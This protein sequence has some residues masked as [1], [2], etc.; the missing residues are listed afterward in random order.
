[1]KTVK[2]KLNSVI[3]VAV[4]ICVVGLVIAGSFLISYLSQVQ[5]P[6][7]VLTFYHQWT[8]VGEQAALNALINVYLSEYPNVTVLPTPVF[9]LSSSG[10]GIVLF[11]VLKPLVFS[12]Q[13]PD[14]FEAHA[15]YEAKIYY[16]AGLLDPVD[17][18]WQED[19]LENVTPKTIQ[20]M[21]QFDGHY[22]SVPADMQR[23][24]LVWYNKPLLDKYGIDTQSITS[25]SSFFLACDELKTDGIQY[26]IQMGQA[27]TAAFAF[28]QIVASQGIGFYQDWIN[29]K[30]I[31]AN[32]PRLLN[33]LAIFK[34]Y[35][36]YVNPD[37]AN[38]TWNAATDRVIDGESAFNIDGDWNDGE[39]IAA[40]L[41]YNKDYGTFPV[42]ET[43]N[44]YGIVIDAFQLPK[45]IKHHESAEE[46]LTVV[47]SEKGQDA[48]N[49][50]KGSISARFDANVTN[51][52]LYQKTAV[53]DFISS[54]YV[55]PATSNAA[56]S[57]F[58]VAEQNMISQF[59]IDQNVTEAADYITGY[60][61]QISKE[62][63]IN[64]QL[65]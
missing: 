41:T 62:Y 59:I 24:N 38:I 5:Q 60:T 33:S 14:S 3:L 12:G 42:P 61:Q 31:S 7:N 6:A 45:N 46:W 40:N 49:P 43:S 4:I 34:K 64:W 57:D 50:L 2:V 18:I 48:F 17:N 54:K 32:D 44:M 37:S 13:A 16:D 55:F 22:Y 1:M 15:G 51:Y 29:G 27:W 19:N 26:P 25:W 9:S 23:S 10:G 65:D 39:F 53:L 35:L 63:T 11:N 47:G 28:D 58:G 8:S 20:A 21:C 30:V 56:P 36:S 52:D